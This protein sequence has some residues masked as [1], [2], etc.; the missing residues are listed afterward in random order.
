M[1]IDFGCGLGIFVIV[2][3]K[4]GVMSVVGV[5]NDLQVF[6]VLIDNVECNVVVDW[7][8]VFLLE[9]F[10][11]VFVDVFVVNI[12]VGLFGELVFIFVVVVKFGVLFVI[13]GIFDGQQDELFICYGEWFDELCVDKCEDWVCISGCCC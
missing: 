4:F 2:V 6:I 7:L 8:V 12:F 13:L 10:V 1:V 5:D 3:F 11:G 9:D